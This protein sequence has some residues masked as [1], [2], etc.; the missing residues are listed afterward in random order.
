MKRSLCLLVALLALFALV[1][2]GSGEADPNAGVYVCTSI[3]MMGMEVSPDSVFENGSTLELKSG[4]KGTVNMDGKKAS[5]KWTLDGTNISVVIEGATSEGTLIDGTIR[6]DMM[7]TG[8][9]MI[10]VL[11]PSTN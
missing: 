8:M 4:G 3:E 5:A 6:I 10:Y 11:E 1:A 7:G 9:E 2:C